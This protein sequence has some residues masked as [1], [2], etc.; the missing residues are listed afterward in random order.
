MAPEFPGVFDGW[1]AVWE[2]EFQTTYAWISF[3]GQRLKVEWAD[4][5]EDGP[6]HYSSSWMHWASP[7]PLAVSC[8]G[9]GGT[10]SLLVDGASGVRL[11][12][13][14]D[15]ARGDWVTVRVAEGSVEVSV[16]TEGGQGFF[17]LVRE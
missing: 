2:L 9:A 8:I 7:R 5:F 11:E 17:R 12:R 4:V 14:T 13:C 3:D 1:L 15:L 10:L 6:P 16:S